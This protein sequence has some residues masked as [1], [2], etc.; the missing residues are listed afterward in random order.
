[1]QILALVRNYIPAYKDVIEGGWDIGEIAS[2]S[3]DL[4]GKTVGIVGA[5]LNW[6]E[7]CHQ[8]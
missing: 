2:K 7:T 6:A 1:M 8:A 3:H 5:G 4:E